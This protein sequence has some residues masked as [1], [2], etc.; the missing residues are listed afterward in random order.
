MPIEMLMFNILS[1][2]FPLC[3]IIYFIC[4]QCRHYASDLTRNIFC[5][6]CIPTTKI[7]G[8]SQGWHLQFPPGGFCM[9]GVEIT[10]INSYIWTRV[11]FILVLPTWLLFSLVGKL[12]DCC[13]KALFWSHR[14]IKYIYTCI[15]CTLSVIL[16]KSHESLLLF[17]LSAVFL[18]VTFQKCRPR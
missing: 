17:L 5:R 1:T 7:L 10:L 3:I 11:N 12:E 13:L 14:L 2:D 4:V 18:Y 6:L 16:C 8:I 9:Q 15:P